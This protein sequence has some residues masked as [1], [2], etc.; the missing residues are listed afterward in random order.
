MKKTAM[1]Q[2][3]TTIFVLLALLVAAVAI[4]PVLDTNT[5]H[6]LI[7][8]EALVNIIVVLGLNFI[9]G[10]TGQMNLGTAGIMAL[11]AYGSVLLRMKAGLPSLL[12]LLVAIVFGLIIGLALGYPSLRLKGVYLSL[13]T[14]GFSEVVR[15]LIANL[16]DLTNGTNGIKDIPPMNLFGLKLTSTK[17]VIWFYLVLVIL[18]T[19]TAWRV[20]HSK[21]GRVFKAVRDN[22]EAVEASGV[23]IASVK[24][25]A[26]TL[27]A[28]YGCIGGCLYA[29]LIGYVN[30]SQ[31]TQDLSANYL[32][33][34]M[35]GGIGSVPGCIIGAATITILPELLRFLEGYYWLVFGIITLLFAIFLP[36]GVVSLF[37]RH[38]LITRAVKKFFAKKEAAHHGGK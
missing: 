29:F 3:K 17:M 31:F 26:F 11:G 21:W 19:F 16:V 30:P 28:I 8:G 10:L 2:R 14:I 7:L 36:Y 34:M 12:T 13:T 27:A 15:L 4:F 33:M 5:Y 6:Q 1:V 22:V 18:L 25:Q 9:T 23:D 38:G 37:D 32:L 24:I 35:F 20:V